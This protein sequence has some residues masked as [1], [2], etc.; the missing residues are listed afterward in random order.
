MTEGSKKHPLT[1]NFSQKVENSSVSLSL[2]DCHETGVCSERL[3]L[4]CQVFL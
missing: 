1:I 3:S 4:S 2:M